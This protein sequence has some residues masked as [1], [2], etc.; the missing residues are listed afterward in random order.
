MFCTGE[1]VD[2]LGDSRCA[3]GIGESDRDFVCDFVQ[4]YDG[5]LTPS[6]MLKVLRLRLG[7]GDFFI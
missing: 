4:E 2:E 5:C 3:E 6:N 7:D 1:Y